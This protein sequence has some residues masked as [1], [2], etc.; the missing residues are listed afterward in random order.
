LLY[1]DYVLKT[2]YEDNTCLLK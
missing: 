2:V 1:L